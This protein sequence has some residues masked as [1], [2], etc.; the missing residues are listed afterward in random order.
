MREITDLMNHFRA[1]SQSAWNT[2]FRAVKV[3]H[4][5]I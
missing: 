1:V 5:A 4:H 2:G 3:L